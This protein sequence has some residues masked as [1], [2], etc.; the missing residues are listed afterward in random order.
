MARPMAWMARAAA[1]LVW[2]LDKSSAAL[3]ALFGLRDRGDIEF[4]PKPSPGRY[5]LKRDRTP[6]MA[7]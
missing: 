3:I 6:A 4:V 1:P 7:S 2:L 5:R